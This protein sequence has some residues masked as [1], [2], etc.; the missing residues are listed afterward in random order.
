MMGFT[1]DNQADAAMIAERDARFGISK[2]KRNNRVDIAA[3][4]IERGAD[5]WQHGTT[6]QLADPT[7]AQR[8][9]RHAQAAPPDAP[10]SVER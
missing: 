2:D 9:D 3:P 4:A 7:N 1:A 6:I 10:A 5:A 8:A